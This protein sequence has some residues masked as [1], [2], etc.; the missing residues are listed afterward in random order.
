MELDFSAEQDDLRDSIR[1]VLAKESPIGLARE[2][3]ERVPA[4]NDRIEGLWATMAD[5]GWPSLTVPEADGGIGLGPIEAG[6]LAEELGRAVTPG[7][8]LPT[9]TQFVPAVREL[10]SAEQRARFLTSVAEGTCC[11]TLALIDDVDR[12]LRATRSGDGVVLGG[13]ARYVM[14]ADRAH[15]IVVRAHSADGEVYA[16]VVPAGAARIEP[17]DSF[18]PTRS[19]CTLSFDDVTLPAERVLSGAIDVAAGFER[20][21][22]EA[23]VMLSLEMVGTAQQAFDISLEY[24]KQREQFGV[25]IG[26]FQAIK[27]KLADML[28]VL[29]RARS[30]AWFAALCIAEDDERRHA[31]ASVAKA[32]ASDCQRLIA[33]QAVQIHGGIGVTWEY[34]IQ[35]YVKRLK[36]SESLFGDGAYH[37]ARIATLIGV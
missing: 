17:I 29:E 35:L 3:A 27:H 34:D 21:V 16:L 18:D 1:V 20:V 2:V 23:A 15:E 7:P 11:G 10:G 22:E 26:S 8:M 25:P 9:I 30:T 14:E 31:A 32:A 13:V 33:T 28:V 6:I 5:L 36:G 24:A 37:R 4:A 19:F 12:P